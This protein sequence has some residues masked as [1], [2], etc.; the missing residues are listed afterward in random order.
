MQN[1]SLFLLKNIKLKKYFENHFGDTKKVVL[2]PT[3][4][5]L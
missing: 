3:K 4:I 2:L 5:I 1:N